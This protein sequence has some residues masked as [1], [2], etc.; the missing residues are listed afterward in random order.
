VGRQGTIVWHNAN[1]LNVDI[2]FDD[3]TAALSSTSDPLR[4]EGNIA[5]FG[6]TCPNILFCR[7]ARLFVRPGTYTYHSTLT[8]STGT[9][10]VR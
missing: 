3:P 1:L 6:P 4:L 10:I 5:A 2:V 7:R 9:I 8:A